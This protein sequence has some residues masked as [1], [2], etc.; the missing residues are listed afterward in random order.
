M[1]LQKYVDGLIEDHNVPAI[2]LAV[3][4]DEKIYTAAGGTLNIATGVSATPDSIFQIGSISKV[5]T[6][7]LIMKLVDEGRV[8]LDR[9]I[10]YYLP[11]FAIA[12]CNAT[13]SITVRH[14]L[15][16]TSGIAGDFIPNDPHYGDNPIA[17]YLYRSSQLPLVHPVGEYFSYS[18]AAYVIAG[19]LIE[20]LTG[21]TWF[22]AMEGKLFRPLGL[23][24]SVCRLTD[25]LRYRAAIGH[26]SSQD[27]SSVWEQ[28]RNPYLP[29]GLSPAGAAVS[30]A[31]SDLIIFA[32]AH[33]NE[34][35]SQY[36]KRWLS[37]SAVAQM[38]TPQITLPKISYSVSSHAGLGWGLSRINGSCH[39][40]Y[41]HLGGTFG[42][43][44]LL[45]IIPD[46]GLCVAVL[47]NCDRDDIIQTIKFD[48]FNRLAGIDLSEPK[49]EFIDLGQAQLAAM[50]GFYSSIGDSYDVRLD[51]SNLVAIHQ[52]M[53]HRRQQRLRL[54]ATKHSTFISYNESGEVCGTLKFLSSNPSGTPAYLFNEG[55]MHRR[56]ADISSI[57]LNNK[58]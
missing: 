24:N 13:E 10:K 38:Q 11:D 41:G 40:Y 19:R 50:Q 42:Q 8:E 46:Q 35:I 49:H 52:N 1:N 43:R 4:H 27:N 12:D 45:Q 31:A 37:E 28:V 16:H 32:R 21:G 36:G 23:D 47:T 29:L 26:I 20:V 55:R 57:G 6:A 54:R 44:S 18:N 53:L 51:D 30:M 3:W 17:C 2:S 14:L 7:S 33:M 34:G 25:V 9:P 15:N 22:D 5:M 58:I 39:N 48:L 56:A